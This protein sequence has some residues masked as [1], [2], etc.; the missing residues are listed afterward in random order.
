MRILSMFTTFRRNRS[1]RGQETTSNSAAR[2]TRPAD[3]LWALRDMPLAGS[4]AG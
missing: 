1:V 3:H 2:L 4:S